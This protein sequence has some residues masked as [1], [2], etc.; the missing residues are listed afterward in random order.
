MVIG[1]L[2]AASAFNPPAP[3]WQRKGNLARPDLAVVVAG[4]CTGTF[5]QKRAL[6]LHH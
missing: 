3:T 4:P 1:A 5:I 2:A 6:A